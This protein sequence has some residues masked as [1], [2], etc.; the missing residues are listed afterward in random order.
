MDF[1][2]HCKKESMQ[3]I[4]IIDYGFGTGDLST[5]IGH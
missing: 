2:I 3:L 5:I 1:G 4:G